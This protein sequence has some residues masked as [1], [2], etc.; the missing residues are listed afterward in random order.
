M[1]GVVTDEKGELVPGV[2]VLLI[3]TESGVITN[4]D[5][6]YSIEVPSDD[7]QLRFSFVGYV[8]QTVYVGTRSV[9][10]ITLEVNPQTLDNDISVVWSYTLPRPTFTPS[11]IYGMPYQPWG[12]SIAL[13]TTTKKRGIEVATHYRRQGGRTHHNFEQ[14]GLKVG[15]LLGKNSRSV[16]LNFLANRL[17]QGEGNGNLA[18]EMELA[19]AFLSELPKLAIGIG[20]GKYGDFPRSDFQADYLLYSAGLSKYFELFNY[21]GTG[22]TTAFGITYWDLTKPNP[23]SVLPQRDLWG[24]EGSLAFRY[25][26]WKLFVDYRRLYQQQL[27]SIGIAYSI[28]IGPE[29]KVYQNIY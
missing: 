26:G 18:Y 14:V 4:L 1:T 27:T 25:E 16:D 17:E 5:G 23:G 28:P 21:S 11:L 29:E 20:G 13:A 6:K 12:G 22:L 3:E 2:N 15:N 19:V 10:D 8:T 7:S 24:W 9:I